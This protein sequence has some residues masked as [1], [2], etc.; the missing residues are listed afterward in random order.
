MVVVLRSA[1]PLTRGLYRTAES[2]V[3]DIRALESWG[4]PS[5]LAEAPGGRDIQVEPSGTPGD[6][7]RITPP[8]R[9]GG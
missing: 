5:V 1:V 2:P 6:P 8:R 4:G 9:P 3:Q 7:P